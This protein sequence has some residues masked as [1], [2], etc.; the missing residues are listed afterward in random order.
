MFRTAG[1]W[2]WS[3]VL[4]IKPSFIS[5]NPHFNFITAHY[6]WIL[7]M[8][9]IA[10]VLI[11]GGGKGE[12]P[13]IDSLF[14]A[15]GANTQAG[16]NTV[17]VNTLNTFQQVVIYVFPMLSSPITMHGSVVFLR[18]YWF[19]KRFQNLVKE[20]RH[21][22]A[23]ISK[24]RSRSHGDPSQA[25]KGVGGR[26]ITVLRET[27]SHITNDGMIIPQKP[28][29]D[30]RGALSDT[31]TETTNEGDKGSSGSGSGSDRRNTYFNRNGAADVASPPHPN[32]ISFAPT[33]LRS[34]GAG[35]E[36]TKFPQPSDDDDLSPLEQYQSGDTEVLRI[37]NPRDVERGMGPKRL[38]EGDDAAD[39]DDIDPQTQ[40]QP[41]AASPRRGKPSIVIQEPDR[42]RGPVPELE[43]AIE[44][45]SDGEHGVLDGMKDRARAMGHTLSPLKFRK[46]RLL[47]SQ[48]KTHHHTDSQ[49]SGAAARTHTGSKTIERVRSALGRDKIMDMPYLSWTPTLGRNSQFHNLTLEQRE[50]LGGIE[51]RSLRTLALV[52]VCYFWG[53]QIFGIACMLPYI[54]TKN[55]YGAVVDDAGLGRAWWAVF[56]SNSLFM[57]LGLTLTPDS[58]ISF[59]TSTF[60]MMIGALLIIV[61]NTGF[62]VMMRFIIWI[63]SRIVPRGTG[64]WEELRFLLDHPRRCFTLLFPSSATWWLFL[65]LMILNV[66]DVVC[67]LV[68][69]RNNPVVTHLPTN[70][71][72]TDAIFQASSTRTAGFSC[73]P[74]NL[75]HPA[76][77]TLTMIMMYISVYPIAISIRGTNVYEEKSLGVYQEPAD[78]DWKS[79]D[80]VS[81]IG[82]HLRRQLSFDLW[83]V[84]LG[85][86]ILAITEASKLEEKKF[87][88]FDV[89]FEVV[90]A[91]GTVGLSM[92]YGTTNTSL[93]A[94]FT[95]GG[96]LIIIAMMIRGRHRGLPYGLDRAIL[97]PRDS[98]FSSEVQTPPVMARTN[99]AASGAS[100]GVTRTATR[101]GSTNI[102][103][104]TT[105]IIAQ[106]LHPGPTLPPKLHR[107][108]TIQV[109]ALDEDPDQI[110]PVTRART[111]SYTG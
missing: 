87:N 14:F 75:I 37:P 55:K 91:Y 52:L 45:E 16:L 98:R 3:Q 110:T 60:V 105:N 13:Y 17:D 82:T 107:T 100:L 77:Q 95:T 97:L 90:S 25:E 46:P 29:G 96:K 106:M 22:R 41:A 89:L 2:L 80:T 12:L 27:G 78:T 42:K 72:I 102:E 11:Y 71:R 34:D 74:I 9:I 1:N 43:D 15:S 58:M 68:L 54:L 83:F 6:F 79:R 59:Q 67:L 38:E 76:V 26:V 40:K 30:L 70:V 18:L 86:F 108:K 63:L 64:L 32:S 88:M 47:Q 19:E 8:S 53:F 39:A 4:A 10:S 5:K 69:D 62:P 109:G 56:T 66:V 57:D 48:D 50:E 92:G 85:L 94:Q 28:P 21:R 93:V 7:S 111:Y 31:S 81:Y 49:P 99:T 20:A 33:V 23:S 103:R 101:R 104:P 35:A 84:F 61:G 24:S 65:V 73:F 51:Y 36:R 44:R